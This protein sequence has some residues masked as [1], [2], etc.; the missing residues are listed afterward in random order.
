MYDFLRLP[1]LLMLASLFLSGCASITM[2]SKQAVRIETFTKDEQPVAAR[3]V[4]KN[5]FG[6]WIAYSPGTITVHRSSQDLNIV[7][8]REKNDNAA[9]QGESISRSNMAFA[10]NS[11]MVGG[12]VGVLIDHT[13]GAGYSYPS[14]I[15]II[16]GD[17]LAYDRKDEVENQPL[18]GKIPDPSL[19]NR[20][21]ARTS[22][23]LATVFNGS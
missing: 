5:D 11:V 15:K 9:G 13:T 14:W 23:Q 21:T 17:R 1:L 16:M 20:E 8:E 4:A 7:C 10:G 6:E 18:T 22:R 19:H 12:V 2:D 3:C